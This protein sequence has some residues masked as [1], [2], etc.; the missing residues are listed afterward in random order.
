M[1]CKIARTGIQYRTSNYDDVGGNNMGYYKSLL[2]IWSMRG[3][4]HIEAA[5]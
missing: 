1:I 5:D 3:V 2:Y 4:K